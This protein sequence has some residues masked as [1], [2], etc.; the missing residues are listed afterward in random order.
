[1]R[2]EMEK[3]ELE[4][5]AAMAGYEEVASSLDEHMKEE[6]GMRM[7]IKH[8]ERQRDDMLKEL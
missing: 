5:M 4:R 3:I 6:K 7:A 8:L 1:M 2:E